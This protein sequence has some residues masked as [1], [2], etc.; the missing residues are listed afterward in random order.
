MIDDFTYARTPEIIFGA[1]TISQLPG[2]V[3]R[4]GQSV[5]AVTGE[6]SY[7]G[8]QW[9]GFTEALDRHEVRWEHV[10]I[11]GEPSPEMIDHAVVECTGR[12]IDVVVAWGGG[13]V[14]DAGKAI[15]AMLR[16]EGS[17]IEYLEGVGEKTPTGVKVPFIAVPTTAGTGSEATK[18]AVIS[19]TGPNGFK[20]SLRHDNYVPD[21]AL[22]DPELAMRCRRIVTA[23][24]GLDAITQ[25]LES[26]VST[27]A[28]PMT[29]ALAWSGLE[30]AAR[31]FVRA[32]CDG[33]R[34]IVARS[35]MAY[36]ALLSGITLAN[37]GLGVVHGI[38][39]PFG[40]RHDIAHG[41]I[42]GMLLGPATRTTINLLRESEDGA[43]TLEK[44]AAVGRLFS[45]ETGSVEAG[46]ES[47]VSMLE[48]W[49]ALARIP[50]LTR[51]GIK[52]ED[53]PPIAD[54]AG[55]K[56]NPAKLDTAQRLALLAARL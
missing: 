41:M 7:E 14:I 30:R 23:S 50:S 9:E 39:G 54:A 5:L 12:D 18:N 3:L 20:K 22:I 8:P 51:L 21:V 16:A 36:A 32:F 29:D 26:L 49:T 19:Q 52:E 55:N 31:S 10:S 35:D 27:K 25:L 13:S 42:C 28:S 56:N 47:L 15:S 53:L 24:C 45:G 40:A 38:A 33:R 11:T 37:A 46:C 48:A 17:V 2:L 6:R 1:G 4:H 34:D 44:Y 43:S